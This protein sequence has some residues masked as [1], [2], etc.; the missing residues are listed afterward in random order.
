MGITK[1]PIDIQ[2]VKWRH[3]T[4]GY[5]VT[6]MSRLN[7]SGKEGCYTDLLVKGTRRDP[8][9]EVHWS[10]QLFL[11]MFKPVGKKTFPTSV[12]STL[13]SNPLARI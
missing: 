5:R 3:R 12:W 11:K 9:K 2:H 4:L 7:Y 6:V 8:N 1:E 10:G 13:S